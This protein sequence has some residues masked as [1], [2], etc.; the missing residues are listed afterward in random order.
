[1]KP[2]R[3]TLRFLLVV[4][5]IAA[6]GFGIASRVFLKRAVTR[7]KVSLIQPGMS[8]LEIRWRL[9]APHRTLLTSWHY[10]FADNEQLPFDYFS[11]DFD[12]RDWRVNRVNQYTHFPFSYGNR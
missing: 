11:V 6:V 10:D 2:P 8:A 5:T 4:V 12:L 9:G 1:M 3:F 7:H